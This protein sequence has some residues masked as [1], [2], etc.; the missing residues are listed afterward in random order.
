MAE[1]RLL[2]R[3]FGY[4]H[5][6]YATPSNS[7]LVLGGLGLVFALSGSFTWLAAASSLTRLI[8]YVLCIGALPIIRGRASPEE[9][10]E[11][12]RLKGGYTIPVLALLLCLWI[13]A[14]ANARSW[15]VT[16]SLLAFGLVLYALAAGR[17]ARAS[18]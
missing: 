11:A 13:G 6:K 3:W 14:Q 18:S 2:P 8:S 15:I 12:Y 16:G 9:Q 4:V 17:R 10:A 1:E 5:D 7:I